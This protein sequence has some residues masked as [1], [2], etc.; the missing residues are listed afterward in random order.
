MKPSRNIL[1][2]AFI[3]VLSSTHPLPGAAAGEDETK[4]GEEGS[5]AKPPTHPKGPGAHPAKTLKIQSN[6]RTIPLYSYHYPK[7]DSSLP[8]PAREKVD[9][10]LICHDSMFR[11]LQ[12]DNFEVAHRNIL[13]TLTR[14]GYKTAIL[15]YDAL[16][17]K[18][19]VYFPATEQKIAFIKNRF[20][21][22]LCNRKSYLIEDANELKNTVPLVAKLLKTRDLYIT[23]KKIPVLY[24]ICSHACE[25]P[26]K[27]PDAF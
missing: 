13:G 4:S 12:T 18:T 16:M 5:K 7:S 1:A 22:S 21:K 14:A 10:S 6:I 23:G 24:D 9:F 19:L 15:V 2:L 27:E 25:I 26:E 17:G 20:K 11:L 8:D 3:I